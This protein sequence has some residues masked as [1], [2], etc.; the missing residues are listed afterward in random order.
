MSSQHPLTST[1]D[2]SAQPSRVLVLISGNGSNLQALIDARIPQST[3]AHVISNRRDAYG[4]ERARLAS[5]ATSY[6][7]L[8]KYK[9]KYP[10]DPAGVQAAREEY[11]TDLGAM[12]IT[13]RPHLVVCAGFMHILSASFCNTLAAADIAIINLHPALPGQFNGVNAIQRAY[14]AYQEGKITSTGVMIHY[15]ISEVDMGEAIVTRDVEMKQGESE[16]ELEARMHAVEHGLI[17][18]GT[19]VALERIRE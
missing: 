6:H 17:V 15:V 14:A 10:A 4:L 19:R 2:S 11:D 1:K 16:E 8:V 7:N 5:I 12:I 9:K 13:Q 18:E 3:I